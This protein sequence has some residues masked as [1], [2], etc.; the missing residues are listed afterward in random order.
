LD[1]GTKFDFLCVGYQ[2]NEAVAVPI[3]VIDGKKWQFSNERFIET[4][5]QYEE[6]TTWTYSGGVDL[7]LCNEIRDISSGASWLELR[8]S[9]CISVDELIHKKYIFS[10]ESF[11]QEIIN[12][13][14]HYDGGRPSWDFSDGQGLRLA[15]Q[16]LKESIVNLLPKA[17]RKTVDEA[18]YFA[19]RN[20]AKKNPPRASG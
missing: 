7:I 8:S 5:N 3:A 11:F 9:V 10:F 4:K 19:V 20:I 15:G 17:F 16:T 6:H 1:S 2:G 12:F 18:E 13:A 14:K